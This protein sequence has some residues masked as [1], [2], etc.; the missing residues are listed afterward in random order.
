MR[1]NIGH[2]TSRHG[3]VFTSISQSLK[4]SSIIKSR[5]KSYYV[6]FIYLIPQMILSYDLGPSYHIQP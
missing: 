6:I 1:L 5:P 3:L 2:D 4:L